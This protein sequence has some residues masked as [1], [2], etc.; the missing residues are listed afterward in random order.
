MDPSQ[1][2]G[3]DLISRLPNEI[4][5]EIVYKLSQHD[6]NNWS[7][8]SRQFTRCIRPMLYNLDLGRD[9]YKNGIFPYGAKM[10][11]R[12]ACRHSLGD[13]VRFALALG[14][15]P[16]VTLGTNTYPLLFALEKGR[17]DIA[18]NLLECGAKIKPDFEVSTR[19]TPMHF[20]T[21]TFMVKRLCAAG[22]SYK[23]YGTDDWSFRD[24]VLASMIKSG[25][26]FDAVIAFLEID[27]DGNQYDKYI[28]SMLAACARHR[29][30]LARLLLSRGFRFGTEE[31]KV[32]TE[33]DRGREAKATYQQFGL[34]YAL[35]AAGDRNFPMDQAAFTEIFRLLLEEISKLPKHDVRYELLWL[36]LATNP[37]I[38]QEIRSLIFGDKETFERASR[39]NSS[40]WQRWTTNALIKRALAILKENPG[41]PFLGYIHISWIVDAAKECLHFESNFHWDLVQPVIKKVCLRGTALETFS[42]LSSAFSFPNEF[43]N[44]SITDHDE[45]LILEVQKTLLRRE[46]FAYERCSVLSTS[47]SMAATRRVELL[48]KKRRNH[49][50]HSMTATAFANSR[51][52]EAAKKIELIDD[53]HRVNGQLSA[54]VLK[55]QRKIIKDLEF[56]LKYD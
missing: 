25:S 56:S 16:N 45:D 11:F 42:A 30:D 53:R 39:R 7:L 36:V 18:V 46:A 32:S 31:S 20:A 1:N 49:R 17:E 35:Q 8:T 38:S 43:I 33:L 21:S 51:A 2:Q 55:A 54:K 13:A 6:V 4:L 12:W 40:D 23:L 24:R 44:P 48:I 9:P 15:N 34:T 3:R 41:R 47:A 19:N 10:S 29:A 26:E 28:Y 27:A 22:W 50:N 52:L 14:A 5:Y 37:R